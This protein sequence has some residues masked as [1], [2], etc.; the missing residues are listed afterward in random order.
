[1]I[2][3][4]INLD[5][6]SIRFLDDSS[7][8]L[9]PL[10]NI[11]TSQILVRFIQNSNTDSVEN[12]SNLLLESI[13]KKQ[14]P[15]S[16]YDINELGMYVEMIFNIA[17]NFYND[18]INE[19]EPILE[20]YSGTLKVDQIASFSRMRI[21][22][23]SEDI[24][25][26]N[27]SISSMNILNRV[28]KKF[29]KDEEESEKIH[30][31]LEEDIAKST[32]SKNAIQFINL[33][34][35]DIDCWLE[36]EDYFNYEKKLSKEINNDNNVINDN[37]I[38]K[39]KKKFTLEGNNNGKGNIRNI[40]RLKLVRLY[41]RLPEAQ[42]KIIKDK[43]SFQIKGYMPVIGNDFSSNYSSSF[44]L[45]REKK[46]KINKNTDVKIN[47]NKKEI[48]ILEKDNLNDNDL[49][50]NLLINDEENI[51][52]T[53]STNNIFTNDDLEIL[54]K[55]RQSG[56]LKSIVFESNIF[57]FNNLQIPI[58]LSLIS[59]NDFIQKYNSQDDKIDHKNNTNKIILKT[60]IRK[61][62][63]IIFIKNKYRMYISFHDDKSDNKYS[64]LYANFDPLK[65]N[66]NNFI[67]Y[68]DEN[69]FKNKGEKTIKLDDNYSKLITINQNDK[70]FFISSNLIIQRGNNDIIFEESNQ[71]NNEF[72]HLTSDNLNNLLQNNSYNISKTFSFL[73][74]LDESFC[75]ENQIPFDL[76]CELS[77][78]ISKET[79][80]RPLKN[81]KFLDIDE[82]KSI[83]K[84]SLNYHQNIFIS[85]NIDIRQLQ[86]KKD[87]NEI[88]VKFYQS[89]SED[90]S[91]Y[92]EFNIKIEE[93][94]NNDNINKAYER[95]Y[96]HNVETFHK[97]KKLIVFSRCIIVNKTDYLLYMKEE[98]VKEKNFS[99]NNL[100][101]KIF[102]KSVNLMNT[103]DIKQTFKLKSEKSLWSQ[104]F[105]IN[106]VG[107]TGVTSL[108]I[109][110]EKDK[111]NI[112]L[113]DVGIS[114]PTSWYFV[115]SILIVIEPRFLLVNKFGF[116]ITYKQYNNKLKKSEN[117]GK[118]IYE[119]K[120]IKNDA[121]INL[122]LLKG[123][124]NMKKMIQIK[125]DESE[126][127]SCPFDLEEMGGVDV[128]IPLSENMRKMLEHENKKISKKIKEWKKKEKLKKLEKKEKNV[129]EGE[130]KESSEEEEE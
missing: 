82:S 115:N 97:K 16:D 22:Y 88:V 10:L 114:I 35:I 49:E 29:N 41:G 77:G 129:E 122:I 40:N 119:E 59:T 94:L 72:V 51:I 93:N 28:I 57:F 1:M 61:S 81:K 3:V 111:N 18:R 90:K 4:K 78:P 27:I 124:K 30:L 45:K 63:P 15:L 26:M 5:K 76:K 68:N 85:D 31:E 116:D 21:D 87:N 75:I 48:N 109:V 7:K 107:N 92:L 24:L 42:I 117:D 95:E 125:L 80:I 70:N 37:I 13:S 39:K 64:L 47:E 52:T 83:L 8:Y 32:D 6:M 113:L 99:E 100:N 14:V 20:K 104:K 121:N 130:E 127:Y 12:I 103:K 123:K 11:E 33:T 120:T 73:F 60:G 112:I 79:I 67:K 23:F 50:E 69:S 66:I 44:I 89:G 43:F 105:N 98:E 62:I 46:Q 19:W 34:G 25:N 54:V 106:T 55:I 91:K 38:K 65:Q 2:D 9:I 86:E 126:N 102:E 108:E 36:A 110:D 118:K 56:T 128:K 17:I 96:E 71:I 53:S 58:S 101:G 84:L 74:I